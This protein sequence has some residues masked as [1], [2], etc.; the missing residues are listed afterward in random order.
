M[1]R[2]APCDQCSRNYDG[3]VFVVKVYTTHSLAVVHGDVERHHSRSA[4]LAF[5]LGCEVI[6]CLGRPELNAA[7]LPAVL[8]AAIAS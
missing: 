6:G 3:F 1:H 8:S 4:S 5:T 7:I 2:Y